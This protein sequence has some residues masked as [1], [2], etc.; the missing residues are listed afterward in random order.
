MA[1]FNSSEPD[2]AV[3]I[4]SNGAEAN[5]N[6]QGKTYFWMFSPWNRGE[7]YFLIHDFFLAA[8]T[9]RPRPTF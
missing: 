4:N 7:T 8:Y 9:I 3:Q 2:S 5:H 1:T 6:Y